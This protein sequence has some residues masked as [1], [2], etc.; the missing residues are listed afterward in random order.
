MRTFSKAL[1]IAAGLLSIGMYS[2]TAQANTALGGNFKLAHA[3]RFKN[4]V[5]PAG[6]YRFTLARTETDMNRLTIHG[7]SLSVQ[8][9]VFAQSACES[10]K[11]GALTISMD[12]DNRAVTALELP[13]YHVDFKSAQIKSVRSEQ[14]NKASAAS[15]QVA[16]HIDPNN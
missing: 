4:T 14:A 3:T 12:G 13:G 8:T 7:K 15:E 10:C 9:L 6:E 16:V 2:S 1:V 5:L 11:S